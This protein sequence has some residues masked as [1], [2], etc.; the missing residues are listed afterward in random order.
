M[1]VEI[2]ARETWSSGAQCSFDVEAFENGEKLFAPGATVTRDRRYRSP[3][4]DR[5]TLQVTVSWASASSEKTLA[6]AEAQL[7]V[8]VAAVRLAKKLEAN[9]PTLLAT[10]EPEYEHANERLNGVSCTP[11]PKPKPGWDPPICSLCGLRIRE[12]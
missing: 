9:V 6:N 11:K 8:M 7:A 10:I 12:R 3:A 4:Y 1:A 5:E 2:R